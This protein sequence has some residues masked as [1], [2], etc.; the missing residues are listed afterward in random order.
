MCSLV[1]ESN[2]IA[3]GF[4]AKGV[5]KLNGVTPQGKVNFSADN[6]KG[7]EEDKMLFFSDISTIGY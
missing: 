6:V 1:P 7:N 4:F 3:H 2:H 5:N